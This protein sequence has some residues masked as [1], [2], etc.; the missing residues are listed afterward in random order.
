MSMAQIRGLQGLL[1]GTSAPSGTP[2]ICDVRDV[3][4]AHIL[5]AEL[6][7][8]QLDSRCGVEAWR[9][10]T[11]AVHALVGSRVLMHTMSCL[12][13][14]QACPQLTAARLTFASLSRHKCSL[15]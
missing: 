2:C 4:R 7:L 10:A 3:A 13:G 11:S 8:D 12:S 5:A 1:E 15:G 6:P 14:R 9:P